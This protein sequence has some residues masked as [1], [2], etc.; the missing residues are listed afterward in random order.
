MP[1]SI[2]KIL[3]WETKSG[4]KLSSLI[5]S[6]PTSCTNLSFK[7]LFKCSNNSQQIKKKQFPICIRTEHSR[8]QRAGRRKYWY[9]HVTLPHRERM[10]SYWRTKCSELRL[11][12]IQALRARKQNFIIPELWIQHTRE[13]PTFKSHRNLNV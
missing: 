4:S 1:V 2:S 3:N 7:S 8:E 9:M 13:L 5:G 10:V 6:I 11:F 12:Y